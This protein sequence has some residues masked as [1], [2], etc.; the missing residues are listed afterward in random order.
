LQAKPRLGSRFAG[1]AGACR[2]SSTSC[3]VPMNDVKTVGARF[4]RRR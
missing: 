2:G 1:W 4:V 3:V